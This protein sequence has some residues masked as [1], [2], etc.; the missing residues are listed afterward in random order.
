MSLKETTK[1]EHESGGLPQT[2]HDVTEMS[3]SPVAV[4]M[5]SSELVSEQPIRDK[6]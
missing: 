2:G 5:S 1:G 3:S 6:S 4:Q